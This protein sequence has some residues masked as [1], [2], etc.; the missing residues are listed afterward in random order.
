MAI[1]PEDFLRIIFGNHFVSRFENSRCHS[2]CPLYSHHPL[3]HYFG[4]GLVSLAGPTSGL[5]SWIPI[6]R[7]WLWSWLWCFSGRPALSSKHHGWLS[8]SSTAVGPATTRQG[9]LPFKNAKILML[10]S[11]GT[12][13]LRKYNIK[14]SKFQQHT[15]SD[16]KKNQGR[17]SCNIMWHVTHPVVLQ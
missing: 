15:L 7:S 8:G 5:W 11:E 4:E 17:N 6:L 3:R 10:K 9:R 14:I 12:V 2:L 13:G 16:S 1:E